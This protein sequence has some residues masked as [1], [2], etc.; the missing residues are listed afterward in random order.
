ML[1]I[2]LLR[3]DLD[4]TWPSAWPRAASR[5]TPRAFATLEGERKSI[6]TRTQ[7]LQAQRNA[8]SKQI[9]Q[10]KAQGEDAAAALMAEAARPATQLK[11]I[12]GELDG[13]AGDAATSSSR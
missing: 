4:G 11:G 5:S 1:D 10:A 12:E 6:Q 8:L 9:G 2:Q 3:S 13:A 7:E